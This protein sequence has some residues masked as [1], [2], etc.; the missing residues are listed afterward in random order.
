MIIKSC[1]VKN[2][3][4]LDI[5]YY[6]ILFKSFWFLFNVSCVIGIE[7]FEKLED[8]GAIL[9]GEDVVGSDLVEHI[10]S[11]HM[12][13]LLFRESQFESLTNMKSRSKCVKEA[14]KD[15]IPQCIRL[16][17][18]SIDPNIQ[19]RLAIQLSLCEFENSKID[20][21]SSCYNMVQENDYDCCVFDIERA[22]QHWTTFSGYYREIRKICH[23]ESLP[24]EKEQII[25]LYSN[26]TKIYSQVFQDLNESY[27]D[28]KD[29]QSQIK[30]EFE[31]LISTMKIILTQNEKTQEE[32]KENYE[33]FS[34]QYRT[35][36]LTSL[37]ISKNYSLET[38][39][40][41]EYMAEN[42]NYL[43]FELS[44]LS[45]ALEDHH[46]EQKISNLKRSMLDDF[47]KMSE[48]SMS[49]LENIL[50]NLA[51]LQIITEESENRTNGLATTLKENEVL[52]NSM[53]QVLADTDIQ[54]QEHNEVIRFE[55][56]ETM[57]YFSEYREQAIDNAISD[58]REEISEQVT[59]FINNINL[60]LE[61]TTDKLEQ[62]I[63]NIDDLS[64]KVNNA[65]VYLLEGLQLLTNNGII[66][67]LAMS[68]NNISL[69][70]HW[71]FEVFGNLK[72]E[73]YKALYLLASCALLT[74]LFLWGF[75]SMFFRKHTYPTIKTLPTTNKQ[76]RG[77]RAGRN[78]RFIVNIALWLSIIG[79][80]LLAFLVTNFLIQLKIYIG[81]VANTD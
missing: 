71:C 32:M 67:A 1:L 25:S 72:S 14:L 34:Q 4:I 18:D 76:S 26:I 2:E 11:R 80:T 38:E 5:S 74:Y 52:S 58:T 24:F 57:S 78:F 22:P 33:D 8:L 3:Y 20:Y 19:K 47:G 6:M 42:V 46:F 40:S 23:E 54:I 16:G 10:I 79:G 37:E 73:M 68:Y 43:S 30:L 21:P 75:N 70:I 64:D 31:Q 50:G 60:K 66:D 9:Q 81:K 59:L 36:L 45:V 65:S 15:L 39:V 12:D 35:M 53:H 77:G 7:R 56:E 51:S 27:K 13:S 48:D 55:F 41:V 44:K 17:V 49:L 61:E 69:G 63:D 29:I 62:V 28:S